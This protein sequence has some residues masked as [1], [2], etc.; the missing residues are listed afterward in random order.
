MGQKS[1]AENTHYATKLWTNCFQDYCYRNN[2][3]EIDS[4]ASDDLPKVLENFFMEIHKVKKSESDSEDKHSAH[5]DD[6]NDIQ[7]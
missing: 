5:S 7:Y 2:I 3:G 4:I 6:E 1:K